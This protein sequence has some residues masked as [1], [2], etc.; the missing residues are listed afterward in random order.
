[1]GLDITLHDGEDVAYSMNWLCN[2]FGLCSWAEDN[3]HHVW[4]HEPPKTLHYVTN[5][6]SYSNSGRVNRPLF[7]RVVDHYAET[8]LKLDMSYF[9]FGL[10]SYRQFV[11]PHA[12]LLPGTRPLFSSGQRWITGSFYTD[13]KLAIPVEHFQPSA[14]HLSRPT[15]EGYKAWL[16][17]L[18]EF[19]D[20][21]QDTALRFYCSN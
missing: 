1:M 7:K 3:A 18:V 11:E 8:L 12:H 21:M 14:F 5:H 2:P 20:A 16:R 19:G 4:E 17:E 15:I 6:W 9:F 13:H 10:R